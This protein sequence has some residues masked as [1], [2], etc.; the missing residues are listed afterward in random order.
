MQKYIYAPIKPRP[1]RRA[2]RVSMYHEIRR[3]TLLQNMKASER[4]PS[5]DCRLKNLIE[6]AM[7]NNV[8]DCLSC[9]RFNPFSIHLS[10]LSEENAGS[11]ALIWQVLQTYWILIGLDHHSRQIHSSRRS[12]SAVLVHLPGNSFAESVTDSP[13]FRSN[14][15]LFYCKD[16]FFQLFVFTARAYWLIENAC[17]IRWPWPW[18]AAMNIHG[19]I[20]NQSKIFRIQNISDASRHKYIYIADAMYAG[21]KIF[22]PWSWFIHGWI[23]LASQ[24]T[25]NIFACM[26][27]YP[28]SWISY[29]F[30]SLSYSHSFLLH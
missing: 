26:Y 22:A 11:N 10:S 25:A 19:L 30:S 5:K 4:N 9:K 28:T 3:I 17:P 7:A 27:I 16:V 6:R 24:C 14:Q 21:F 29:C 2:S 1:K 20:V 8:A 18:F 12:K 15:T 13:P 23:G